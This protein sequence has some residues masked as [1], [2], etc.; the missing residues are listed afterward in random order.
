MPG[1][2]RKEGIVREPDAPEEGRDGAGGSVEVR[3]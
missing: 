3:G 2:G 1:T